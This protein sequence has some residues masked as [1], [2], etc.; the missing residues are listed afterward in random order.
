MNFSDTSDNRRKQLPDGPVTVNVE[1]F[2][3][4]NK[5]C[6]SVEY[7]NI[8]RAFMIRLPVPIDAEHLAYGIAAKGW[9]EC[10]K[11]GFMVAK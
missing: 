11:T 3:G 10:L 7:G 1:S 4:G 8:R 9:D 5:L 2:D 6:I